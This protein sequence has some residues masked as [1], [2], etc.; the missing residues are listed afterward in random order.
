MAPRRIIPI[1]FDSLTAPVEGP[2]RG[3]VQAMAF[4]A[5]GLDNT[6][7]FLQHKEAAQPDLR[8]QTL[9]RF[10]EVVLYE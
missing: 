1:H 9:P 7:L 8:F 2:F 6:L 4:L 5:G 3:P 10:D